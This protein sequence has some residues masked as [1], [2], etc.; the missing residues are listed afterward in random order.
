MFRKT[1]DTLLSGLQ[2]PVGVVI[3]ITVVWHLIE[4]I[5]G[6]PINW[7]VSGF[8]LIVDIGVSLFLLSQLKYFYSQFV[9]PVQN[10]KQRKEIY[11]RVSIFEQGKRGPAFF[12]KNGEVIMHEGESEKRGLGVIVIDTASAVVLRTDAEIKGAAGP[13]IK[14]T[15]PNEYIAGAVDLRTQMQYVGPLP[16]DIWENLTAQNTPEAITELSRDGFEV[17]PTIS[18]KFS[19]KRPT[20]LLNPSESGVYSGYGYDENAVRNAVANEIINTSTQEKMDWRHLP[21]YL[22]INLWREYVRKFKLSELFTSSI[23]VSGLQTIE[24]MINKRLR[25]ERVVELDDTGIPTGH[26]QESIEYQQLE[27]RGLEIVEVRIHDIIFEKAMQ[28]QIV[29]NWRNEWQ[30]NADKEAKMIRDMESLINA[31]G[32]EEAS[33]RFAHIASQKYTGRVA[34]SKHPFT[35][36]NLIVEP[37]KEAVVNENIDPSELETTLQKMQEV[38]KW[39]LDNN[40]AASQANDK[41]KK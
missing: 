17:T 9:L 16:K 26:M 29:Q 41:G 20:S 35:A 27:T 4:W 10:E 39:V 11:E 19:I 1:L 32:R 7:Y 36:L 25:N 40:R 6:I 33:K 14:F 28:E 15:K 21:A 3:A 23:G 2:T 18:I 34:P 37:V 12:V 30:N 31:H 5:M 38:W 22:V 13:G 24:D 8:M